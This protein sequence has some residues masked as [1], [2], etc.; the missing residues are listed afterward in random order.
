MTAD[1]QPSADRYFG[2]Q[3]SA[4]LPSASARLLLLG[5][6]CVGLVHAAFSL[7]WAAGGRRL[8]STVGQWA[9]NAADDAPLASGLV[10]GAVATVKLVVAVVPVL[11]TRGTV[12][13]PR[14]L[15]RPISW[16]AATVLTAYGALNSV[17]AW[18]VLSGVMEPAGGY[19]REAMIGHAYLW[20]PLFLLWGL[21]L[22]AGLF[23]SRRDSAA[24][25]SP[26]RWS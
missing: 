15:W 25:T 5:A 20:D 3:C 13:L 6:A 14:R 9:V 21:L 10:L 17:V 1:R 2:G 4:P 16:L 18:L 19:D 24:P 22:G 11:A 26:A 12:R 23:V 8:L 7:Y